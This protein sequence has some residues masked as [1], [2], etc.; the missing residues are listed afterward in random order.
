MQVYISV[1][2]TV[3]AATTRSVAYLKSLYFNDDVEDAYFVDNG[4][5]YD[6]TAT[7]TISGLNQ[8]EG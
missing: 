4:L 3:N 8:V 7:T 1:K 5:T 2:R 6:S